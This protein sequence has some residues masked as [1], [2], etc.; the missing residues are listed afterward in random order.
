M[1][2]NFFKSSSLSVLESE[3]PKN[4]DHYK[5][6]ED[7][8]KDYFTAKGMGNY[9]FNSGITVPDVELKIGD[10]TTDYDNAVNIYESF[11]GKLNPVQASDPRLW[12]YLAHNVFWGY[13]RNRWAIEKDSDE[14][15]EGIGN[16]LVGRIGSRYF[17]KASKGKAFARQ[18]I[19]R[20]YWSAYLTYDEENKNPYELTEYFLS[21]Q[22][23]FTA[24]T[25]RSLARDKNLLL[26]ALRA[27]KEGDNLKRNQVRKFFLN[28]NLAGGTIV[29]DSLS[30][31]DA[32]ELAKR[33]LEDVL[34]ENNP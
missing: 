1:I 11:R 19:A 13:M 24:A 34:N 33:T 26:A 4:I 2:L 25:E 10:F 7:W 12:T 14:D 32:Y 6:Q 9:S 18:G 20:L 31:S 29:F 21:K 5:E 22:D 27:L 8:V 30:K 23:I 28:L 17:F 3:I 15:D 16:K